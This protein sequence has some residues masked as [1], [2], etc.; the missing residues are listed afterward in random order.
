MPT[1]FSLDADAMENVLRF[2]DEDDAMPFAHTCHGAHRAVRRRFPTGTRTRF[3]SVATSIGK[4]KWALSVGCPH[5]RLDGRLDE[6]LNDAIA[7]AASLDVFR[8]AWRQNDLLACTLQRHR[9][10]GSAA[11]G[12]NLEVLKWLTNHENPGTR[13][14]WSWFDNTHE[15]YVHGQYVSA[16]AAKGGHVHVLEWMRAD[17]DW[18]RWPMGFDSLLTAADAGQVHALSWLVEHG[19]DPT[20]CHGL[21]YAAAR[22]GHLNVMTWLHDNV[23]I[24][25]HLNFPHFDERTCH[26]ASM[27][28]HVDVLAWLRA[29]VPPCPWDVGVWLKAARQGH[30]H[31]LEWLRRH[32]PPPLTADVCAVAA[33]TGRI[34]VLRWLR[35]LTPPCPWDESVAYAA[36]DHKKTDAFDW[37]RQQ[38]PP[39]P[40]P[41]PMLPWPQG[42]RDPPRAYF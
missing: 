38:R 6:R 30:F 15:N 4:I 29:M 42:R 37:L 2:L 3:S 13:P 36:Y 27:A 24:Q 7:A 20:D 10:Y 25:Q 16:R 1:L 5:G 14:H 32:N 35:A 41:E 17:D 18:Y 34:D 9:V 19:V 28:G 40:M 26:V 23:P 31:V 8:W 21:C 33:E 11:W 22:M 39:C 12:G